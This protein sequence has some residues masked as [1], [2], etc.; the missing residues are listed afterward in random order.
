MMDS[1]M[2]INVDEN[3]VDSLAFDMAMTC[4]FVLEID[5]ERK[6]Y[7]ERMIELLIEKFNEYNS[8]GKQGLTK[9]LFE[10]MSDSIVEMLD[11]IE[12]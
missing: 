11:D 2:I 5:E 12:G 4:N 6:A 1:K 3:A 7:S 9:K 8:L 10:R